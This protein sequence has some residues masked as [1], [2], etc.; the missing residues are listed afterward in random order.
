[1]PAQRRLLGNT[2]LLSCGQA[3]VQLLNFALVVGLARFYGREL[4]GIYSFSMAV[5]AMLCLLVSLGTHGF[6]LQKISREPEETASLTGALFGF[7]LSVAVAIVLATHLVARW[8]SS[9]ATLVWVLTAVVAFHTLTRVNSLFVLGFTARQEAHAAALGPIGKTGLALL[10]AGAAMLAGASA[11]VALTALPLAALVGLVVTVLYSVRRFGPL[12]MRFRRTEIVVYLRAGMPYF[13]VVLLTTLY[14]RLGI[15]L[16]TTFAGQAATGVYAAAE[17]LI[18][19]AGTVYAMFSM[20]LLPVVTQLWKLD[21]GQFA[22]LT[23]RAARAILLVT[24]PAATLL[25]LFA[26]DIVRVLYAHQFRHA[27]VVLA[28]IAWVLVV[29]GIS[30]LLTTAATATDH[31]PVLIRSRLLGIVILTTASIVLIPAYGPLGLV[32][33]TLA[34]ET[35]ATVLGYALLRH[36]GVPLAIPTGTWRVVLACVLAAFVAWLVRD[37]GFVWRVLVVGAA[38]L[39]ALW[40]S[41][42]VRPHDLAYLRAVMKARDARAAPRAEPPSQT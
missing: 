3:V 40:L 8:L 20:A 33:A 19:A 26:N 15:I 12:Q 34:G 16:L 41:G 38:G 27:A 4:L 9:S 35:L 5:G 30:Q 18:V 28:A 29:R 21:R 24:L 11:S 37:L 10:L 1:L 14:A 22:E 7:Q 25:A 2:V 36:A 13:S 32:A 23:Q 17:R 31:Q 42:A 6:L 39:G